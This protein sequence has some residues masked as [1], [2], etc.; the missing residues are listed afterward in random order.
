MKSQLMRVVKAGAGAIVLSLCSGC[1]ES[2]AESEVPV[3]TAIAPVAASTNA[4]LEAPK[5]SDAPASP[6]PAT[7]DP[8]AAPQPPATVGAATAGSTNEVKMVQQ[9]RPPENLRTSPVVQEVIKLA[10][11]GVGDEVI[12]AYVTNSVRAYQLSSDE[13]LY[14]TDLGV[15]TDVITAM[16]QKPGTSETTAP[17]PEPPA[18]AMNPAI[19]PAPVAAPANTPSSFDGGA[20][21]PGGHGR[22]ANA[23]ATA[24]CGHYNVLQLAGPLWQLGGSAGIWFGVAANSSGGE[25][26]LAALRRPGSLDVD[27]LRLVLVFG[28][29][30]GLGAVSLWPLVHLCPLGWVWM[31]DTTWGPSWVSWRYTS[32]HCGWAP[33]P[34]RAHYRSGFGFSYYSSSVGV[35]LRFRPHGRSLHLCAIQPVSSSQPAAVCCAFTARDHRLPQFPGGE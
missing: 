26:E 29:F 17:A 3:V 35:S 19:N 8:N 13:I 7:L 34:P 28:L 4:G 1:L 16:L 6:G 20:A 32:S 2:Q 31:P 14:L 18:M 11:A 10:E 9:V 27:G 24:A 23:A 25:S 5:I 22:G 12:M 33:L 30:L 21:R 15:S